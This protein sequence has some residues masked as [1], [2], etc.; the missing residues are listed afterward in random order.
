MYRFDDSEI[1]LPVFT[2]NSAYQV[3]DLSYCDPISSKPFGDDV[4][5]FKVVIMIEYEAFFIFV[6]DVFH[7]IVV[8][9]E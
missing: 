9:Y 4:M 5:I 1:T 6:F 3:R 2:E 8:K 7:C